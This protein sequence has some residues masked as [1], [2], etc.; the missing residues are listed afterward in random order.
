MKEHGDDVIFEY[1]NII[2]GIYI[3]TNMCCQAH[4]DEELLERGISADL[5]LEAE[6][7]DSPYGVDYFLWLP[8]VDEIPPKPSQL[9]A[10]VAFLRELV[11]QNIKVYVHC[12]H[13]HGRAPTLVAA[14]LISKGNSVEEAISLIASK[15]S[16]IHIN[17]KQKEALILF[18]KE[19]N[20]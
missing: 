12:Q 5:S 13:G 8:T 2:D 19:E 10:G 15:R 1:N 14:Y 9:K 18:E 16:T 17:D 6:K 4:F 11:N 3:G 7:I 20:K